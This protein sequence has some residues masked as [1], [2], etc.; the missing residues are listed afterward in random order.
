[1]AAFV[2]LLSEARSLSQA[3]KL[4]LIQLLAGDLADAA[5]P[6]LVGPS[7]IRPPRIPSPR[8]A[9]PDQAADFVKQVSEVHSDAAV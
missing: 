5:G 2:T 1:M 7:A 9:R 3:D 4:R 6:V 8:L